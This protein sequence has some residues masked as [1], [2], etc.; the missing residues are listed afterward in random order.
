MRYFSAL[1]LIKQ[2]QLQALDEIAM[3]LQV[4]ESQSPADLKPGTDVDASLSATDPEVIDLTE[5]A[6]SNLAAEGEKPVLPGITSQVY[7]RNSSQLPGRRNA[8]K[9]RQPSRL[10]KES[11]PDSQLPLQTLPQP[12]KVSVSLILTKQFCDYMPLEPP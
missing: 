1:A 5:L 9:G 3:E 6:G 11:R 12:L 4:I 8:A 7:C 10:A 2:S